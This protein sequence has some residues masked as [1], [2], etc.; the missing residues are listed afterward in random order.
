[1]RVPGSLIDKRWRLS[2]VSYEPWGTVTVVLMSSSCRSNLHVGEA[3]GGHGGAIN[4]KQS[5]CASHS[6]PVTYRASRV[7]LSLIPLTLSLG[8]TM[9]C[10]PAAQRRGRFRG[11]SMGDGTGRLCRRSPSTYRVPLLMVSWLGYT[12]MLEAPPAR[13][14]A[15]QMCRPQI[16]GGLQL[17][18]PVAYT[19]AWR[20]ESSIAWLYDAWWIDE[21]EK[22]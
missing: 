17:Q 7:S 10:R 5:G 19:Y 13:D 12:R 2:M 20:I 18:S 4:G 9:N 15:S 22:T 8:V 1:M 14:S 3:D 11:R 16:S 6:R 21:A